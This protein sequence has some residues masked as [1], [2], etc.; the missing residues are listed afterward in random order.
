MKKAQHMKLRVL[1]ILVIIFH[2][3]PVFGQTATSESFEVFHPS[4]KR[5]I[6]ITHTRLEIKPFFEK[7]SI[8]GKAFLNIKPYNKPLDKFELDA[9]GMKIRQ[10][11]V[12]NASGFIPV[13]YDYDNW[14]IDIQLN[15]VYNVDEQFTIFIEYTAHPY[16]LEAKGINLSAGKGMY[17]IDPLDKNPYKETQ[18]WTSG[19]TNANSVW[20]PTVDA[21]N[22]RFTQEIYLTVDQTYNTLSNG[23]L[24]KTVYNDD[25]TKTDYW[26]QDFTHSPYL[27]MIAVGKFF[28]TNDDWGPL[29]VS[30]YTNQQYN[31]DVR[32]IFG[33]TPYMMSFFS[34]L[35]GVDFPWEKYAQLVVHD[36]NAAAMENTSAVL[37]YEK[38]FADKYD[39]LDYNFDDVIA[40]E[41]MHQW[42]GDYVTCESWANLTL[43]EAFATYG[44]VLW[45]EHKYGKDEGDKLNQENLEK[46]LIEDY[47][48]SEPLIQYFYEDA[49][50]D[51]F[52]SHRYEKGARVVH[53]LRD[54]LGD[55]TF[56]GGI[57]H[58]LKKHHHQSVEIHDLRMAF[59]EY[60]GED[61]VWFFDQWFM[62]PGHPVVEISNKY[63]A[64]R[65][66]VTVYVK[67]VQ[68]TDYK[69]AYIFP[70]SIDIYYN[71]KSKRHNVWVDSKNEK[72]TFKA[73]E[74]PRFINVDA[75]KAM[76]WEKVEDKS[77]KDFTYQ[78]FNAPLYLDR[79]EALKGLY[80]LQDKN[81]ARKV[82]QAALKDPFWG[83]R[84]FAVREIVLKHYEGND[85]AINQVKDLA[86]SDP[87]S[88]VRR[89]ALNTLSNFDP[90]LGATV[91]DSLIHNDSSRLV[92]ANAL[93]VAFQS[94]P[95]EYFKVAED[96]ES[97]QNVHLYRTI[98][99]I[100]AEQGGKS[101]H[102]YFKKAIW[103]ARAAYIPMLMQ[104]YL[105]F[106]Q[107][108]DTETVKNGVNFLKDIALYEETDL[109]KRTA[110]NIL[111]DLKDFFAKNKAE[112]S[113]TKL[114]ATNTAL[115]AL[116]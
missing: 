21:P 99:S 52:D 71:G 104:T 57:K 35:L 95:L 4:K 39:A 36:F 63:D 97:I 65:Q 107:R 51:L 22:E 60:T 88:R 55:E 70:L 108:M 67:Q 62:Y 24:E 20:F 15:R 85:L 43:N 53:M 79:L 44:E 45:Y 38:Y 12:V 11:Y 26:K 41:L 74:A 69:R 102:P 28:V 92:L 25:G 3:S 72:F 17:F 91:A 115:D 111:M 29:T 82:Y 80:D 42:F 27:T 31:D 34:T 116:N 66:E 6:D 16:D 13:E 89:Y 59:E 48:S 94:N 76:L 33:Q 23:I 90:E 100:Y 78:F 58:Y 56:F 75:K 46:Y 47:I 113:E 105:E 5:I 77:V 101:K 37:F 19:E 93:A 81:D 114:A 54:Y 14:T 7:K 18:L 110:K 64:T 73:N 32:K 109:T 49:D 103:S 8:Y 61:L 2:L 112:D 68:E 87:S 84:E 96:F 83:I 98:C 10:V 106:L 30:Y 50:E 40:H 1:A 9:K 86:L